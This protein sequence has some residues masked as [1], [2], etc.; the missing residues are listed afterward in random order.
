MGRPKKVEAQEVQAEGKERKPSAG[1]DALVN[2]AKAERAQRAAAGKAKPDS[3]EA[4]LVG[5][6]RGEFS[7]DALIVEVY[8]GLGGLVDYAR[9]NENRKAEAKA[10][11]SKAS[12]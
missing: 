11:R 1:L 10:A 12:R 4:K 9:A 6:L 5:R 2:S 7:G 3:A 8:K